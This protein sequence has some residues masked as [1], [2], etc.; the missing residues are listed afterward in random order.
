MADEKETL[1]VEQFE[2]LE[3]QKHADTLGMW[4]F[5]ATEIMFFGGMFTAYTVY[6]M[7]Y[8]AAWALAS[9]DT[10]FTVGTV[11]TF[12]LLTS[13][14]TVVLGLHAAQT[15]KRKA[16]IL[17]LILTILLG[18]CFLGLKGL[19]YYQHYEDHKIPG[20]NFEFDPGYAKPAALFMC[21]YFV[22][23]GVHALHMII[24]IGL[25]TF[26]LILAI[27]DRIHPEFPAQV[28]IIG[29]YWHFVDIVW[30]FLYPLL[31]LVDRH[32]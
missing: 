24:G 19:E 13:S 5:L 22:M 25:M 23:T 15:A 6:R 3:Q 11:N 28:D 27:R 14:L 29:L 32:S 31:Y 17:F 20:Y 12:V 10:S 16:L 2:N 8:P 21:F 7:M 18:L 30:I 4:I 26:L 9:R 1:L